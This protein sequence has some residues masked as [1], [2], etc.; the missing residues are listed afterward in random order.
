VHND[1]ALDFELVRVR[2]AD[3]QD[4]REVVLAHEPGQRLL[5]ISTFRDWAV[6]AYRRDGLSRLATFDY[7]TGSPTEIAFDEELYDV[8]TAGNPEWAPPMIRVAFGSF[9]TPS[10]VVDLVVAT[11]ERRIRK[12]QPVLGGYDPAAYGQRRVWAL[13]EDGTRIPVSLV[14]RRSFGEP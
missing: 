2:A 7:A 6:L 1:Q 11:D 8:G 12:Q 5:G 14:W 10:T 9:V 3:P 4:P 13:A